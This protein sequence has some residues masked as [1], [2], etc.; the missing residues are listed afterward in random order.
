[1]KSKLEVLFEEWRDDA[2]G[3]S[4]PW[5]KAGDVI[6]SMKKTLETCERESRGEIMAHKDGKS[7]ILADG[8]L[9]KLNRNQPEAS[10]TIENF[11]FIP[12]LCAC[13]IADKRA[14]CFAREVHRPRISDQRLHHG[15]A[16]QHMCTL[17]CEWPLPGPIEGCDLN[18]PSDLLR[19]MAV[20]LWSS[21]RRIKR[22]GRAA[23]PRN[24]HNCENTQRH[25]FP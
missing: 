3:Q 11:C 17:A 21:C 2:V 22:E 15:C 23:G 9:G 5:I 7:V 19:T 18:A 10:N 24:R 20:V 1:M 25:R 12:G 8:S 4:T 6:R 16:R 13:R 14:G